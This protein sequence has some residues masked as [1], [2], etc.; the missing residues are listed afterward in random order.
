MLLFMTSNLKMKCDDESRHDTCFEKDASKRFCA[1]ASR[2]SF[3]G[4][5]EIKLLAIN[6]RKQMK[7]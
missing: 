3:G 5:T 4:C 7:W 2:I 6:K 1:C